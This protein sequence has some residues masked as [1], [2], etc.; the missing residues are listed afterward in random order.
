M[1][2][3]NII[4]L[5]LLSG[6]ATKSAQLDYTLKDWIF[7]PFAKIQIAPTFEKPIE[8][9]LTQ[10]EPY[11]LLY[12]EYKGRGGYNWGEKEKAIKIP[13]TKEQH[14]KAIELLEVCLTTLP[15]SDR[16]LGLDGT[17]WVLETTAFQYLKTI[18]WEP[19]IDTAERGYSGLFELR[20]YLSQIVIEGKK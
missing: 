18:I 14:A 5:A 7:S 15:Q 17:T 12:S 1:K 10:H 16:T 4:I 20:N 13:L 19:E 6:C 11:L 2:I 8:Y 3:I 9:E